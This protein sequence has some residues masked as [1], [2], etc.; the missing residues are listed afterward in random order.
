MFLK[1]R[2]KFHQSIGL[3]LSLWYF[4]ISLASMVV[5]F[6][7]V[8]FLV[9]KSM[10]NK[11]QRIVKEMLNRYEVISQNKGINEL[12]SVLKQDQLD[13]ITGSYLVAL[14]TDK[15]D[16]VYI[17]IPNGWRSVEMPHFVKKL[18]RTHGEWFSISTTAYLARNDP[19]Q[20]S[21][22]LEITWKLLTEDTALYLGH[23]A[24]VREE[25]LEQ[26]LDIFLLA[27]VPMVI[28]SFVV[29]G[30]L[31]RRALK[32]IQSL[33]AAI[34]TILSGRLETRAPLSKTENEL[35][36]L[37]RHFNI[38]LDRIDELIGGMHEA[39]DNV[40]HDLRTPLT[41]MKIS[42]EEA[43][44]SDDPHILKEA[45]F[46]CGEESTR[47]AEMLTTLMDVS[48][49]EA[50]VMRIHYSEFRVTTFL[51]EILDIYD[52]LANEKQITVEFSIPE[53]LYMNADRNRLR[54]AVS[55]LV[56]NAIKYTQANGCIRI[57]AEIKNGYIELSVKDNGY[58]I[59]PVDIDK[60]FNRLYRADKSRSEK[61]LGLGLS[62]VQAVAKA[63]RGD[64]SVESTLGKGTT[65]TMQ[66]PRTN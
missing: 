40:A 1:V 57:S 47:I 58:G 60:I 18:T 20:R 31:A 24:E 36:D 39:L 7:L 3:Q 63:H 55:N 48:E 6:S 28:I 66:L 62:V 22:T 61:G 30:L 19:V 26:I 46:D 11:D 14:I 37:A 45:L 16:I 50:G 25:V 54:Q 52:F 33:T 56:D 29:G 51:K 42:I 13:H 38:M 8:F 41:R 27:M 64:V 43:V 12:I 15:T 59:A 10:K 4:G 44:V 65:F 9:S 5:L 49:A 53:G 2:T 23:S 32:P 17:S 35:K 34:K 21:D